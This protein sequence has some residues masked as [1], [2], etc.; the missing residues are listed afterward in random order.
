M[1]RRTTNNNG[2]TVLARAGPTPRTHALSPPASRRTSMY[3]TIGDAGTLQLHWLFRSNI[4]RR[5]GMPM[6]TDVRKRNFFGIGEIIGVLANPAETLRSLTESKKMLEE[7]KRELAEARER[8][9]LTP[10]HTFSAF[11]GFYERP[12]ELKAITRA[13]EGEP[14]FTVLFGASSVGKTALLRQVLTQPRYHVLH[15]DLRIAGFADLASLYMSLSQQMEG[16]FMS[17]AQDPEMPGYE[18]FEKEAWGFKHDRLNVERRISNTAQSTEASSSPLGDIKTSDIARLMELFQSSLLRYW[19][20]QPSADVLAASKA[21]RDPES[22]SGK[23]AKKEQDS[24]PSWRTRM[25]ST[26]RKQAEQK[27]RENGDARQGRG[28]DKEKE[29][30]CPP[31]KTPVFFI[32]EAHK[33]HNE[34]RSLTHR[35]DRPA[36]IRSIDAMKCLLDAMLVITKQDR[37]CHVIHATSDPFYQTWLRQLNIMQHC[38]IITIGDHP[39]AETRKFFRERMLPDVPE[40]LRSGLDFEKLYDAF[41]GKLAHWQDYITDYVNSNGKLDIKQSSHFIQ[42]HALL[43]LHIIHSAQASTNGQAPEAPNGRGAA[44]PQNE[45]ASTHAIHRLSPPVSATPGSGFRIYSPLTA[46]PHQSPPAI[47]ASSGANGDEAPEFQPDFSAY[48]LLRVMNRLAQPRTRSLPYFLLCREMGAKAIDGMVKGRILDLRW[49][50]P[51]SKDFTDPF[52]MSMRVRES[53]RM[54]LGGT[55]GPRAGAESSAT[56]VDEPIAGT[57]TSAGVGPGTEGIGAE[58]AYGSEEDMVP[59]SDE[60][61]LRAHERLM[62]GPPLA[63]DE[64]E[65]VLGPKLVPISPIMRYAM[66][67]VVQEY[68]ADDDRTESEYASL[69]DADVQEY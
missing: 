37:L 35:H 46:N 59:M 33:L 26:R 18:A 36:L 55:G 44:S 39:K 40:R 32:D 63:G 38:K 11:P 50:E 12:V 30:E 16:F 61:V 64:E 20:F 65:E 13:L 54:Q 56:A 23:D 5:R 6:P 28:K 52:R 51:V 24:K 49:T 10:T 62:D 69:S 43:N 4:P 48:Q 14:S 21:R 31:K 15:F 9:Q 1:A 66:Q 53:I 47:F 57:S 27:P 19:N 68:Y 58:G 17:I 34:R 42:A 8:A 2:N 41:G 7:T 3:T 25:F 45:H 29:P 22:R 67:E 60:E